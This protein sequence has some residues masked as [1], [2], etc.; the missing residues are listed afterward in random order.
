MNVNKLDNRLSVADIASEMGV[1]PAAVRSWLKKHPDILKPGLSINN[2][3]YVE[4][5]NLEVFR[6]QYVP[7]NRGRPRKGAA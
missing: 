7:T 5:E 3:I 1:T 4:R 6:R 2:V